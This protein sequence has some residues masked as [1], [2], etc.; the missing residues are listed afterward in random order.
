LS[1]CFNII[2]RFSEDI[3]L[4][5]L[6]NVGESDNQMTNKIKKIGKCI[7]SILPE[8]A[9]EGIT[10]KRGMNRKTAHSYEKMYE[11]NFGQVRDLIVLEATW[12]GHYEPLHNN[13]HSVLYR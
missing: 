10:Q 13:F 6:R 12:F 11:A 5:V 8:I 9:V 7:E 3:D 1:K 4:V 2:E